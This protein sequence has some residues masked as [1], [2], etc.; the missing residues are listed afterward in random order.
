MG[1]E[2][3]DFGEF[4]SGMG[5]DGLACVRDGELH[6]LSVIAATQG[7]GQFRNFIQQCKTAYPFIR[8]WCVTND[9]VRPM[10]ARYGFVRGNDVDKFGEMQ[11][12]WDWRLK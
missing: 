8:A 10:L 9:A 11:E 5:I 1:G 7:I 4:R 2:G 3:S 6:L 12:V